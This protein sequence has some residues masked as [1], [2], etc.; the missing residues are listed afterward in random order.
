MI[1]LGSVFASNSNHALDYLHHD[2]D[3]SP[4]Y[5]NCIPDLDACR[6]I[7]A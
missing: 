7:V 2:P 5:L 1:F 4:G 6:S 3:D